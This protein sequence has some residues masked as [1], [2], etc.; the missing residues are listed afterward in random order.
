ML[1]CVSDLN[2]KQGG[3]R[4]DLA[5]VAACSSRDDGSAGAGIEC[6]PT[7]TSGSDNVDE[8][9]IL[10]YVLAQVCAAHLQCVFPHRLCKGADDMGVVV[11]LRKV[12]TREQRRALCRSRNPEDDV[13]QR[14]R[15]QT[16]VGNVG[17]RLFADCLEQV[18][19]RRRHP[20]V[21]QT[22]S[23]GPSGLDVQRKSQKGYFS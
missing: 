16:L 10:W 14:S 9:R 5:D 13:C 17:G 18:W 21:S 2:L 15:E 22:R 12:Q 4:K 7:I 20:A 3:I 6:P 19:Y 8:I 1:Q 11:E 23:I